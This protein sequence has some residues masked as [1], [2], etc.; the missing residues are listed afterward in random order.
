VVNQWILD[1]SPI[2]SLGKIDALS[3]FESTHCKV[4]IPAQVISEI[5]ASSSHDPAIRWVSKVPKE[6]VLPF[7]AAL[8]II[9]TKNLGLGE[10][11]VISCCSNSPGWKAVLDDKVARSVARNLQIPVLGTLGI[12]GVAKQLGMIVEAKPLIQGLVKAGF[13]VKSTEVNKILEILGENS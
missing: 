12:I 10:S 2:I 6:I 13:H 4:R 3:I 9:E 5:L 8:P 11:A 7:D 1:A